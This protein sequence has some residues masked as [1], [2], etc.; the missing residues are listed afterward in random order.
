MAQFAAATA[1]AS[2]AGERRRSLSVTASKSGLRAGFKAPNEREREGHANAPRYQRPRTRFTSAF[3]SALSH[4]CP[5]CR[6]TT[7]V[8]PSRFRPPESARTAGGTFR[9]ERK[10]HPGGTGV[11]IDAPEKKIDTA[12]E[13]TK[14]MTR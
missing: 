1:V 6:A 12:R 14:S 10:H 7:T 3:S 8:P 11:E 5:Y 4:V 13:L 2:G 9:T